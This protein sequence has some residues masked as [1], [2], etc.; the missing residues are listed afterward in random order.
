MEQDLSDSTFPIT[1]MKKFNII[2]LSVT[3]AH[4]DV[5]VTTIAPCIFVQASLRIS[6][7]GKTSLTQGLHW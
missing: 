7:L 3:H 6:L 4:T 5:K 1:Y 2:H